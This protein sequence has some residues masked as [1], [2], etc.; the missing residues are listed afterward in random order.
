MILKSRVN[1]K[2]IEDEGLKNIKFLN[3]LEA[4]YHNERVHGICFDSSRRML[5]VANTKRNSILFLEPNS[6]SISKE[7]FL[8]KDQSGFFI[9][10]DHNNINNVFE[11]NGIIFFTMHNGALG[12]KKRGGSLI[13]ITDLKCVYFYEY[14][15]RGIHDIFF[16]GKNLIFSDSFGYFENLQSKKNIS[17]MPIKNGKELKK[18]FFSKLEN[19]YC[20]R[21]FSYSNIE[22]LVG[23]SSISA[24]RSERLILPG[25]LSLIKENKAYFLKSKFSQVFEIEKINFTEKEKKNKKTNLITLDKKLEKLIG[26]K[27][28]IINTENNII[29]TTLIKR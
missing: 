28:L 27:K 12:K 6:G 20:I 14:H 25:G 29:Q 13:G 24:R 26:K 7:I 10:V 5:C 9:S 8:M 3:A 11:Y 16:D 21:G 15:R 22:M 17:G 1:F 18:F 4:K 23:C 19:N 2:Q